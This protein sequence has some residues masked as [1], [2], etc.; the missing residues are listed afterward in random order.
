MLLAL[1]LEPRNFKTKEAINFPKILQMELFAYE[2][3]KQKRH[4]HQSG[5]VVHTCNHI[6]EVKTKRL[7]RTWAILQ[8]QKNRGRQGT[9]GKNK[10]NY[11]YHIGLKLKPDHTA[12]YQSR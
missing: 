9:G 5:V 3:I 11:Y 12:F 8:D 7:R 1:K 10:T 4:L 2:P 6:W